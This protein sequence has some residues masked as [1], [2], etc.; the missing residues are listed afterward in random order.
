DGDLATALAAGARR[1]WERGAKRWLSELAERVAARHARAGEVAFLLEPD[2]KE[3]RGGLRD[4]HALEWA[5][6]TKRLLFEPDQVALDSAYAVIADARVELQ[7]RTRSTSNRLALQDQDAVA[8]ALDYAD[9]DALMHAVSS[10]ARTI[11][12]ASD[13]LWR[14]IGSSLRGPIGRTVRRDRVVRPGIVLRDGEVL[15]EPGPRADDGGAT[16]VLQAAAAAAKEGAPFARPS[17][18][19]LGELLLAGRAAIGVIETLDQ[20]GVWLRLLPEWA[21]VR[22]RPQRNAYHRFTVDRH[23]VET[24]ANAAALA[25]RVDRPDLLAVGSLLHDIGKGLPG[26]HTEAGMRIVR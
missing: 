21:H 15:V 24:A 4:V 6:A 22:S 25:G 8:A 3:G 23:L 12:W 18:D 17:R 2:L 10:A 7:R 14:R 9:A 13:D 16:L 26:D 20:I 1:Q 5:V 19:A 11:A